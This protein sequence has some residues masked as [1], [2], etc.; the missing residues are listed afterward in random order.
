[1]TRLLIAASGTGG[2]LFPALSVANSLPSAWEIV[3]LGVPDRMETSIVPD[4]FKLFTIKVKGLQTPGI[5]RLF[6]LFSLFFSAFTVCKILR[7]E[8][9]DIVFTTGGYIAAPAII[10]AICCRIPVVLHESNVL[11]GKVTRLLGRFCNL[12]A[13]G[14]SATKKYLPR[15][16]TFVTGTPVRKE[17]YSEQELSSWIPLGEG[18]LIVVMGGSQGA[19]GLNKMVRA[20]LPDLLKKGCRVVH[21][22]GHNECCENSF[23]HENLIIKSF[24]DEVPSLL[25][26]ADL[27]ISRAGAGSISELAICASSVILVP[28]PFAADKHQDLNAL[29]LEENG[30]ALIVK[31]DNL[32]V[33]NLKKSIDYLLKKEAGFYTQCTKENYQLRK[34]ISKLA[35]RHSELNIVKILEKLVEN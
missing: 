22:T 19:V 5:S 30:A 16:K 24:T 2:H 20:V 10:G 3:W 7:R 29:F 13:I 15:S 8:R 23:R 28:Y 12:V 31:Q 4:Y 35:I 27:V 17:F 32:S 14:L 33:E 34:S 18:P 25:Q 6:Q 9:I 11:P 1:M 26:H 21:L